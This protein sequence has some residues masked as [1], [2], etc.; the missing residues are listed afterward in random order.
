MGAAPIR[1]VGCPRFAQEVIVPL[2]LANVIL[3]IAFCVVWALVG[4]IL[5][6]R[7]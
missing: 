2:S 1:V 7:P 5:V 3:S 4:D 6:R